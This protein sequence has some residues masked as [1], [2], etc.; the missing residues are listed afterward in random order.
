MHSNI[1]KNSILLLEMPSKSS[2]S[3][4]STSKCGRANPEFH[5]S[6]DGAAEAVLHSAVIQMWAAQILNPIAARMER[7]L[8]VPVAIFNGLP[9]SII[10]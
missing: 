7:L 10:R 9:K 8:P 5:S 6:D 1:P 2:A 3:A 4:A